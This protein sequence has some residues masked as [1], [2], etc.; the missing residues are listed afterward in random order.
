MLIIKIKEKLGKYSNDHKLPSDLD[1]IRYV[2][3]TAKNWSMVSQKLLDLLREC[4]PHRAILSNIGQEG[5]DI[6]ASTRTFVESAIYL[7]EN[8][9]KIKFQNFKINQILFRN[10]R[11]YLLI[12]KNTKYL[13]NGLCFNLYITLDQ[14][15]EKKGVIRI[16]SVNRERGTAQAE[17]VDI[18]DY[19]EYWA[20]AAKICSQNGQ[21]NLEEHRL[22][23]IF[24]EVSNKLD[25]SQLK[26]L[27]SLLD[28]CR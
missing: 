7:K 23:A 24:P 8:F 11:F 5:L 16:E 1:F 18:N 6:I 12:S 19:Q 9:Q 15:E 28:K 27:Q 21:H 13:V 26:M 4:A 10:N 2:D 17:F 25:L 14:I 3:I 22:E 20:A